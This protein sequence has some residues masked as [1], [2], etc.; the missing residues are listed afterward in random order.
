M[1]TVG[2]SVSDNHIPYTYNVQVTVSSDNSGSVMF[3][4]LNEFMEDVDGA[5]ITFLAPEAA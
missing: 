4:V 1:L 5:S 2:L 3:D